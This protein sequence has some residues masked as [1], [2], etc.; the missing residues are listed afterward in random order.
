MNKKKIIIISIIVILIIISFL[1]ISLIF[2]QKPNSTNFVVQITNLFPN[3]NAI[4]STLSSKFGNEIDQLSIDRTGSSKSEFNQITDFSVS[5]LF[6]IK[7]GQSSTTSDILFFIDKDKGN[8]YQKT[9]YEDILK[10]SN[11][12][13]LDSKKIIVTN[14]VDKKYNIYIK[15]EVGGVPYFLNTKLSQN[16]SSSTKQNIIKK[17]PNYIQDI[18]PSPLKDSSILL[19]TKINDQINL[20]ITDQN[21]E[22]QIKIFSS[23]Y[24]NWIVDWFS[25]KNIILSTRPSHKL[26]GKAYSLDIQD[27][28]L[29]PIIKDF[30]GLTTLTSYS[31][32]YIL[33]NYFMNDSIVSGLY[34]TESKVL[35]PNKLLFLTN[36]CTWSKDPERLY[37]AV[38]IN[39]KNL[40]LY[41]DD[42]YKGKVKTTYQLYSK[43]PASGAQNFISLPPNSPELKKVTLIKVDSSQRTIY[44]LNSDKLYQYDLLP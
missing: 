28:S 30:Y 17:L 34:N 10:I 40:G 39:T 38:P 6:L 4:N 27:K 26:Q 33:I 13:I 2:T 36:T 31:G 42:L 7:D 5:D 15:T 14:S 12:T 1:F 21:L 8:L 9:K 23:P 20:S 19:T 44:L 35:E 25:T 29:D 16:L 41:P 43:E 37:C 18:K 32:K 24:Q 11:Q 3:S 22:K